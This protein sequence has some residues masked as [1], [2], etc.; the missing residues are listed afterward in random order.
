MH[1]YTPLVISVND[2]NKQL[3]SLGQRKL[4]IT[5]RNTLF[6][7]KKSL[8]HLKNIK[9][10]LVLKLTIHVFKSQIIL[11]DIPFKSSSIK[12]L[13]SSDYKDGEHLHCRSLIGQKSPA[14]SGVMTIFMKVENIYSVGLCLCK[15]SCVI[16]CDSYCAV[17]FICGERKITV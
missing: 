12:I 1:N 6:V 2:K 13:M 10:G 3:T 8:E 15:L 11:W 14:S 9:N 7:W 17:Y 4:A 5:L 16:R